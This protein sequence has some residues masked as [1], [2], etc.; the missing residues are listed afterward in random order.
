MDRFGVMYVYKVGAD[1]AVLLV[2]IEATRRAEEAPML[3]KS[4]SL[5][6][7]YK[8]PV[9]LP[10]PVK[11]SSDLSFFCL[12]N[13]RLIRSSQTDIRFMLGNTLPDESSDFAQMREVIS[14]LIPNSQ[15]ILVTSN[16]C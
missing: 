7:G 11:A 9:S 6:L 10:I 5:R 1:L 16:K 15:L 12:L 13:A 2:E 8:P 3:F 4:L 14:E